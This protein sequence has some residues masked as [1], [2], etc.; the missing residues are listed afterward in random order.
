M[1]KTLIAKTGDEFH[2]HGRSYIEMFS[3]I[4]FDKSLDNTVNN[5][6]TAFNPSRGIT[7]IGDCMSKVGDNRS[8]AFDRMTTL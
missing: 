6:F 2:R 4:L 1:G 7:I 5:A 3:K 8:K